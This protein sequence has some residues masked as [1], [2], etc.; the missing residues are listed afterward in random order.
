[1]FRLVSLQ[2]RILNTEGKPIFRVDTHMQG[3]LKRTTI[4]VDV[5]RSQRV[6][7][8]RQQVRARRCGRPNLV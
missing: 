2:P 1:M 4:A 6:G 5:S 8:Q 7:G 3:Q